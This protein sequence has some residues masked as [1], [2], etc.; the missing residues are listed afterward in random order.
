LFVSFG[1]AAA[2]AITAAAAVPEAGAPEVR[3]GEVIDSMRPAPDPEQ[4]WALYLPTT[5]DPAHPA[6]LLLIFDPRGRGAAAAQLF[7]PAAERFGWILASSNRTRSDTPDNEPNRR[8]VAALYSDVFGRVRIDPARIYAAGFSGGARIAVD[9]ASRARIAG[10]IAVGAGFPLGER[11][12]PGITFDFYGLIGTQ[13]FNFSEM[14]RLDR[15]LQAAGA[16]RLLR[17]FDGGHRWADSDELLLAIEWLEIRAMKRDL[18]PVDAVLVSQAMDRRQRE[19]AGLEARGELAAASRAWESV[20]GDF[21]TLAEI[22]SAAAS[23]ARLAGRKDVKHALAR[24]IRSEEEELSLRRRDRRTLV[25]AASPGRR[26]PALATLLRELEIAPTRRKAQGGDPASLRRLE[27]IFAQAAT[28]IPQQLLVGGENERA[29]VMLSLAA[30]IRPAASVLYDIAAVSSR[31]RRTD[32][33]LEALERAVRAGFSD[34]ARLAADPD[35]EPLSD[36]ERFR[37]I[38]SALQGES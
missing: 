27:A 29:L 13:D 24:E 38:V 18:R 21:E 11:P 3:T 5:Y 37:R 6:P 30:E 12:V 34:G 26:I 31:L 1:V 33:A 28:L 7:V 14:K 23:A 22:A 16:A 35:F 19:A 2:L 4:T 15:Q 36:S 8:A 17:F 32:D 20:V 10:V 9:F 25:S